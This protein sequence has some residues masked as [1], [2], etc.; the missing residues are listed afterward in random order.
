MATSPETKEIFLKA[1]ALSGPDRAEVLS[2][3]CLTL[4]ELSGAQG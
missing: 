1:L 4:A 3:L 2:L